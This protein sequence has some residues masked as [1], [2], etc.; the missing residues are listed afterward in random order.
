MFS[1]QSIY[2]HIVIYV[3]VCNTCIATYIHAY[4]NACLRCKQNLFS[5]LAHLPIFP[6]IDYLPAFRLHTQSYGCILLFNGASHWTMTN[7]LH[8][9]IWQVLCLWNLNS[10]YFFYFK[11]A[12]IRGN[13]YLMGDKL[14]FSWDLNPWFS[15]SNRGTN[16]QQRID[17]YASCQIGKIAV[18]ARAGNAGN[19]FPATAG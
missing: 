14:L 8:D 9:S 10:L 11:S 5:I 18:C 3:H 17:Q 15:Y 13:G 19:V 4:I 6:P 7:V 2:T 12:L 16:R 1:K